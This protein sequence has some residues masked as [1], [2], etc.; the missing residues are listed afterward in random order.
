M[1]KIKH[2]NVLE[3]IGKASFRSFGE[4]ICPGK[5]AFDLGP[6]PMARR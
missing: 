1:K 3:V 4:R 5:I 2:E 6:K